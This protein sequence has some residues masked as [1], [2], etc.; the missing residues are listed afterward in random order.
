MTLADFYFWLSCIYIYIYIFY[1][2]W[3]VGIILTFFFFFFGVI[4]VGRGPKIVLVGVQKLLGKLHFTT[5]N[6]HHFFN[7][8]PKLQKVSIDSLIASNCTAVTPWTQ[9]HVRIDGIVQHM[10]RTWHTGPPGQLT[11]TITFENPKMPSSTFFLF[12]LSLFP[13]LHPQ[14]FSSSSSH[15]VQLVPNWTNQINSHNEE[16]TWKLLIENLSTNTN[17]N[18]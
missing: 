1:L 5:L 12:L 15:F 11:P 18:L 10:T 6:D 9:N 13:D 8:P 4:F 3:F 7:L 14:N 17:Y 2:G 16:K